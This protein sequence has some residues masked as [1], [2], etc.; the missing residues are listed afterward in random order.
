MSGSD[1]WT[2]LLFVAGVLW[3][4]IQPWVTMMRWWR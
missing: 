2:V 3:G 4:V 1:V